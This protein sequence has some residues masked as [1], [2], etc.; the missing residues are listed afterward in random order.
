MFNL[1][2]QSIEIEC[3]HC[4]AKTREKLEWFRS[5]V[6]TCGTGFSL[7]RF[8]NSLA[9]I[10]KDFENIGKA[11]N[12]SDETLLDLNNKINLFKQ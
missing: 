11:M 1:E 3:A 7:T 4:R 9:A 8:D 2:K 6:C 10:K 12:R 5:H